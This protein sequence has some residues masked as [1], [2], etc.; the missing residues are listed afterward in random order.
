MCIQSGSGLLDEWNNMGMSGCEDKEAKRI[1][2][3]KPKTFKNFF[4]Y[5]LSWMGGGCRCS[6]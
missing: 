6:S 5:N 3:E 2:F 4:N 1:E